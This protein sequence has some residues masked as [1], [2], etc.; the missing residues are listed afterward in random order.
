M[1]AASSQRFRIQH[2]PQTLFLHATRNSLLIFIYFYFFYLFYICFFSIR[3]FI[4]VFR[5]L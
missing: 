2:S 4:C 3:R 5:Q 1:E